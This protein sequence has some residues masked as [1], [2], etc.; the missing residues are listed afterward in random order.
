MVPGALAVVAST[1]TGVYARRSS[2]SSG[3]ALA[4]SVMD[5]RREI[6]RA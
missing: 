5:R 1:A 3:A 4:F 2:R 6:R